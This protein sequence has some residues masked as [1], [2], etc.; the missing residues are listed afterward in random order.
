MG[1]RSEKKSTYNTIN[2]YLTQQCRD[3]IRLLKGAISSNIRH[4]IDLYYNSKFVLVKTYNLDFEKVLYSVIPTIEW[5]RSDYINQLYNSDSSIGCDMK[6]SGINRFNCEIVGSFANRFDC[7]EFKDFLINKD[8]NDGIFVYNS[9]AFTTAVPRYL[10]APIEISDY[11]K[12]VRI[13]VQKDIKI[14]N[15]LSKY[16]KKIISKHS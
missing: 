12:I 14:E 7:I 8:L 2:I 11:P 16:I 15:V 4:S 5:Y 6:E 3:K 10:F 1:D 13:C 9:E